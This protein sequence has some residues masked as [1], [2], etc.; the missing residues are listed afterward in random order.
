M[1]LLRPP[2]ELILSI[3]DEVDSTHRGLTDPADRLGLKA[4]V[5][6]SASRLFRILGG[7]SMALYLYRGHIIPTVTSNRMSPF[8]EIF[9]PAHRNNP[10]VRPTP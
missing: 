7:F 10:A 8:D 4:Y 3:V 6:R 2:I 5:S 9:L 1:L